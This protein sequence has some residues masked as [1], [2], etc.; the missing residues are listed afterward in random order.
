MFPI[1][2]IS[3]QTVIPPNSPDYVEHFDKIELP[4]REEYDLRI[5]TVNVSVDTTGLY[6]ITS[7]NTMIANIGTSHM[8]FIVESG[9]YT[10]SSLE[11]IISLINVDEDNYCVFNCQVDFTNANDLRIILGYDNKL[12]SGKSNRPIDISRGRNVLRVYSS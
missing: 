4:N 8:E 1:S 5:T 6:N 11:N 7:N 10:M 9:Y 3:H 12:C 2:V